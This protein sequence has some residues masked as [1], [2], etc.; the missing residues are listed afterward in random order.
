M[1][2]P[3]VE[4]PPLLAG[5]GAF[6]SGKPPDLERVSSLGREWRI[7]CHGFLLFPGMATSGGGRTC[8]LTI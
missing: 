8:P 3:E 6:P 4:G 5:N 2:S 7:L 1:E